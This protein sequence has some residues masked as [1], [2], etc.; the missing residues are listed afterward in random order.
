MERLPI[1]AQRRIINLEKRVF[2]LQQ[3]L[4]RM[5]EKHRQ[6]IAK[7]KARKF[8]IPEKDRRELIA[9]RLAAL[10]RNKQS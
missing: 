3:Q 7:L 6:E 4:V 2:N 9:R 10:L 1:S 5:K 8:V